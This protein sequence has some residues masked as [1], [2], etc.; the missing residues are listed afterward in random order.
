M[1]TQTETLADWKLPCQR[2]LGMFTLI[3]AESA[4]FA[5]FVVAYL[6]YMG[7]NLNGPYPS[8][9]LHFPWLGSIALFSSSATIWL[10]ERCLHSGNKPGFGLWWGFTIALGAYFIYFTADE[11]RHL[12]FEKDLTIATNL[13]GTTFYSLVGLHAFHVIVGL[14][15]LTGV[16]VADL[17]G[18]LHK[19]HTPH[20][21]AISYYWHF[22]DCIWIVVLT[23]VYIIS[24][25]IPQ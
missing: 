21:E 13:F 25:R 9:V 22:V 3:A 5:I 20:V 11:W 8:E 17:R 18:R 16:L 15:L 19:D 10:A 2:K 24:V 12:I 6:F 7:K 14:C 23:V 1:S 4:L